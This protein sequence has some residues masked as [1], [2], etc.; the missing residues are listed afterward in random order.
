MKNL[1]LMT[2]LFSAF[3][4]VPMSEAFAQDGVAQSADA[5]IAASNEAAPAVA[6]KPAAVE[7]NL[8]EEQKARKLELAKKMH[9]IRSTADQINAAIEQVAARLPDGQRQIFVN[10]M[11]ATLNV[12]AIE[13]ISIDAMISVFSLPELESMVEY[14]SKP[15][16]ISASEK[17]PEW[18]K[19]VQPEIVRLVDKA[20][21]RVQM[22][23]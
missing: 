4:F 11:T 14:Y 18:A 20:M 23:Q 9:E 8:T 3:I 2:A 22:G 21:M 7:E 17:M 19:V 1:V 6:A 5:V 10:E 16:A 12:N 15:E 13:R